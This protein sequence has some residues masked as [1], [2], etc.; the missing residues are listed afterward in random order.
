MA[1]RKYM[2]KV[3]GKINV[4]EKHQAKIPDLVVT[5]EKGKD[6]VNNN[7]VEEHVDD[8]VS[9]VPT[10][11]RARVEDEV[12]SKAV[13]G[14]ENAGVHAE[15]E[16]ADAQVGENANDDNHANE[17]HEAND[18]HHANETNEAH[19]ATHDTNA[20][21][22]TANDVA[23]NA[24]TLNEDNHDDAGASNVAEASAGGNLSGDDVATPD[25]IADSAVTEEVH[26]DTNGN[27]NE[28]AN[29]NAHEEAAP[30]ENAD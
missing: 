22:T 25:D 5:D 23:D 12:D 8:I 27:A 18:A 15:P 30:T 4:G 19:D 2:S 6:V 3:D 13:E 29:E 9:D 21:D 7:E 28:A 26:N 16:H 10:N 11:K 14:A 17:T 20:E 1:K 24:N